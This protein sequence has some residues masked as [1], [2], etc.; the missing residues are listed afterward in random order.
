MTTLQITR[1]EVYLSKHRSYNKKSIQE[2]FQY[3]KKK[4]KQKANKIKLKPNIFLIFVR[5]NGI[6]SI[7]K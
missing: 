2:I 3:H 4:S 7:K 6:P 5:V 1:G